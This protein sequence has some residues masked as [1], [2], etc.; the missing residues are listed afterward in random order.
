MT[1]PDTGER[2]FRIVGGGSDGLPLDFNDPMTY[3]EAYAKACRWNALRPASRMA[4]PIE[5]E[6]SRL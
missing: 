6:E 1:T 3:E 2:R 5:I 4:Y